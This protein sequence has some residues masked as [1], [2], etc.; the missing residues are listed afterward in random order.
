MIE[1]ELPNLQCTR[2]VSTRREF[3]AVTESSCPKASRVA[4]TLGIQSAWK[5]CRT[6]WGAKKT[7]QHS[8]D[9]SVFMQQQ[10]CP[11]ASKTQ[12]TCSA[13]AK[14]FVCA[15]PRQID[16]FIFPHRPELSRS[17][18][19]ASRPAPRHNRQP[20]LQLALIALRAVSVSVC[21]C[22]FCKYLLSLI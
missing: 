16:A 8:R 1:K 6:M 20:Q 18:S 9:D 17:H 2:W 11:G 4:K 7:K 14:V 22:C 5:V 10:L 3:A 12:H 13:K 21:F 19:L 15:R